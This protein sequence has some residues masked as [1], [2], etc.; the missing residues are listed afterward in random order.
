MRP[1]EY[2]LPSDLLTNTFALSVVGYWFGTAAGFMKAGSSGDA[3]SAIASG[4]LKKT[5]S[6]G[7]LLASSL[8]MMLSLSTWMYAQYQRRQNNGN[9][10]QTS[11]AI[12]YKKRFYLPTASKF[13]SFSAYMLLSSQMVAVLGS[14][15]A[16]VYG[17][18]EVKLYGDYVGRSIG[19]FAGALLGFL[20]FPLQKYIFPRYINKETVDVEEPAFYKETKNDD[21]FFVRTFFAVWAANI[22]ISALVPMYDKNFSQESF[23]SDRLK[24]VIA[25]GI[26]GAASQGLFSAVSF[27]MEKI[28]A[29]CKKEEPQPLLDNEIASFAPVRWNAES[30]MDLGWYI[31]LF[32]GVA[33]VAVEGDAIAALQKKSMSDVGVLKDLFYIYVAM[34][35]ASPLFFSIVRQ[36][37][38]VVGNGLS[39]ATLAEPPA[40]KL[41]FDMPWFVRRATVSVAMAMFADACYF[42]GHD[43]NN[44]DPAASA[45]PAA[46]VLI[47]LGNIAAL[48]TPSIMEAA[49]RKGFQH[50]TLNP[51]DDEV[52]D[53]NWPWYMRQLMGGIAG[54]LIGTALGQSVGVDGQPL[55]YT[56]GPGWLGVN[57]AVGAP[58]GLII[59]QIIGI[60]WPLLQMGWERV[61]QTACMQGVFARLPFAEPEADRRDLTEGFGYA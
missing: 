9:V 55:P 51:L 31:R 8:A 60:A 42:A 28:A 39:N 4:L 15:F 32:C 37:K 47:V 46:V 7:V 1:L 19:S 56:V 6:D 2:E 48:L 23:Q 61:E 49:Y 40:L 14:A 41:S 5:S 33:A 22:I 16:S 3:Q 53:L 50:P 26:L 12:R 13:L 25:L 45:S 29:C 27:F 58:T 44:F 18:D 35:M 34:E 11:T 24:T 20:A 43:L 36:L 54:A 10:E 52:V 21:P 30:R 38:S 57:N 59:G 17:S